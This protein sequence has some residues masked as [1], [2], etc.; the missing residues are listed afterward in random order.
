PSELDSYDQVIG[1]AI[2]ELHKNVRTVLAKAGAVSGTYRLRDYRVIAG[3]PHTGTV[4]KEYGC[5]YRVDLAKAYFSP[6]LSYEHNRVA[7]L[8]EEGETTVDMFA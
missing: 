6:R 8:V 1:E 4:H 3:E 2:L 5:Q 7:S